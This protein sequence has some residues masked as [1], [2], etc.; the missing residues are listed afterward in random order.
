VPYI[1]DGIPKSRRATWLKLTG[2]LHHIA[3]VNERPDQ[4]VQN[5]FTN[6]LLKSN[7]WVDLWRST[8]KLILTS[9]PVLAHLPTLMTGCLRP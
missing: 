2:V 7:R 6:G 4:L 1:I 5:L 3:L 8:Y 9:D